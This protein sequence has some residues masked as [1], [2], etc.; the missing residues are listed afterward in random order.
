MKMTEKIDMLMKEKDMN[1]RQLS[2]QANIPYM[3]IVSFYDKGTENVKLSTLKKLASFFNV[4]LDYIADVSITDREYGKRIEFRI[5]NQ[6]KELLNKYGDLDDHG[7]EMV[8]IVLEKE[9]ARRH[10]EVEESTPVISLIKYL[11]PA[12]AGRGIPLDSVQDWD[13]ME[14]LSNA[15]TRRA[16]YCISVSGNSMEP[17]FYDGDMLLVKEQ[18]DIDFGEIG[19]FLVNGEGYIKQKGEHYLISLN[20]NVPNVYIGDGDDIVCEGLVIGILDPDWI[21]K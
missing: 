1:K 7:K 9:T 16:D 20:R 15:Y 10:K 21:K 3:T 11:T 4:S 8:N 19:V 13:R 5:S 6:E 2:I 14:V 17:K 18:D 12:S